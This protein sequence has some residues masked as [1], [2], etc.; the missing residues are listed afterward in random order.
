MY[1]SASASKGLR[2][3]EQDR[4][5]MFAV[6][7]FVQRTAGYLAR[8]EIER[9]L[10]PLRP[11]PKRLEPFGYKVYSQNDED[12]ILFEI[13]RR[14]EIEK[15]SF[16]EIGVENGLECNTLYMLHR[17]WRGIWLEGNPSQR[18]PIVNK[19]GSLIKTRRLSLRV[20]AMITPTNVNEAI[21]DTLRQ[22]DLRGEDLDFLSV[23]IDG[24]DIHLWEALNIVPK[25]ICIE[26]NAK[27]PPPLSKRPIFDISRMWQGT[28]FMGSSLSALNDVGRHKGYT[29]VGT[30][31]TGINAFFVR[32]DLVGKQFEPNSTPENLFNPPRY[33]LTYDHFMQGIGHGPDF[34]PYSDLIETA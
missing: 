33:W 2:V 17:G 28:D 6:A 19:F 30:N 14:L 32:N 5:Y 10:I 4:K 29:L 8:V 24:N 20:G 18:D 27:F 25:V 26:Y 11:Q 31:I 22:M 34:G 1:S 16:C 7:G 12:G 15:G 3:D 21:L 9:L 13:F 23:D